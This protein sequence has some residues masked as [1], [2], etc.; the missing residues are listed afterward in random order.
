[1]KKWL[2]IGNL[3]YFYVNMFYKLVK[4]VLNLKEKND[5]IDFKELLE[6]R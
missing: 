2:V 4:G 6:I 3:L 1:M 5:L